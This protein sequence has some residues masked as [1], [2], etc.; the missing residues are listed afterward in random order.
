MDFKLDK[1]LS[2]N[3]I[4]KFI[5]LNFFLFFLAYIISKGFIDNEELSDKIFLITCVLSIELIYLL[6]SNKH[7]NDSS[8]LV[9]D[10]ILLL[11]TFIFIY[12]VWNLEIIRSYFDTAIFLVFHLVLVFPIIFLLENESLLKSNNL[13]TKNFLLISFLSLGFSGILFQVS[14]STLSIFL[15]LSAL[16]I[17]FVLLNI[18]LNKFHQ[19]IDIFLST[20]IFLIIIKVFLLSAPKDA[21]HYSWFL[22]PINSI[23]ENFKLLEDAVSQYGYL[24]ILFINKLSIFTNIDANKVFMFIIFC[25]FLIFYF[26]FSLKIFKLVKL[27]Y[28]LLTLFLSFLIFGNYGYEN[29]SGAMFIPS[30]S[31]FRFL[32][33]LITILLFIDLINEDKENISKI[34][35]FYFSFIFSVLWSLESLVF[36]IF[37]IFSFLLIKYFFNFTNTDNFSFKKIIFSSKFSL[38]LGFIITLI[39]FTYFQDKNVYLFYEHAFFSNSSLPKEIL[40][41]KMT[42]TFLFLLLLIYIILRDSLISP[43]VFYIN[44]IW[45]SL[46][47][48]YSSYFLIRSVDNNFL[49]ILPFILF[50][51]CCMKINS[52]QIQ[53]LRKKTLYVIIL[54][55]LI[56]SFYSVINNKDKFYSNF[57]SS[58]FYNIPIYLTK[59]YMPNEEIMNKINQYNNIPLTLVSGKTLHTPNIYLPSKGYGLPILPLE[60][61]NVLRNSTKQKLMDNYF[62]KANK[63][64]IL[65]INNCN[66]YFSDADSEINSKIFLGKNVNLKKIVEI[67]KN[68]LKETLY[69]L[70]KAL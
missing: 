56:S 22:G 25:F 35:I 41:N 4:N 40:N 12:I 37:P 9:S 66:F 7:I 42:L 11:F 45:F 53:N 24:N 51:I 55:S 65:C 34:I 18:L 31:V 43:K 54:F 36:V 8:K 61:F 68:Q 38:T 14:Y 47:V 10:S 57:V 17:I 23:G 30:S 48:A 33:S 15:I 6:F 29:L 13:E 5:V 50:I 52:K 60:S 28:T 39:L 21:F 70:S 59:N 27:N 26:L 67:Q 46:F 44:I 2:E 1:I 58:N 3:Q 69:L 19:W 20:I 16:S 64:L 62:N 32:P 63:H 49:N